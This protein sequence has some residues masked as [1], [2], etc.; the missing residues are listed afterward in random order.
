MSD[1]VSS[2]KTISLTYNA[3]IEAITPEIQKI[4]FTATGSLLLNRPDKIRATRTGGYNAVELVADGKTVSVLSKD[5]NSYAQAEAPA[6]IDQ[7]VNLLRDEYG[8]ELPGADLLVSSPYDALMPDVIEAKH[9]GRGVIDGVEC[10]HLAF[11]NQETDW[12]LWIEVGDRPIP[13]KYIITSKA[14]AAAPQYTLL[15][16]DWKT[17]VE[18]AADAFAFQAPA[19]AKRVDFK[20]LKEIDEVPPGIIEGATR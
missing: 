2:L 3:D 8:M 18:V 20:E 19:D 10:E 12:Q 9:V 16:R 5:S 11:R 15:I 6:D 4:Q 17:D 14:T 13:R 1:Y 7:L